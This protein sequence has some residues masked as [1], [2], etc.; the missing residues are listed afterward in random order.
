LLKT[1]AQIVFFTLLSFA[2]HLLLLPFDFMS[3]AV[4]YDSGQ[5]GVSYISKSLDSFYP[6]P[7][8][9]KNINRVAATSVQKSPIVEKKVSR[10]PESAA[11]PVVEAVRTDHSRSITKPELGLQESTVIKIVDPLPEK[12]VEK[13]VPVESDSVVIADMQD[14]LPVKENLEKTTLE[15]QQELKGQPLS[16]ASVTIGSQVGEEFSL[17]EGLTAQDELAT[18]NQ[19]SDYFVSDQGNISNQGFKDALPRYDINPPPQYPQVAKLRGWEGKVVFEASILKNGRVGRLK[20]MA[21]S[22]YRS[23][24]SAARKAISRW[25]F[26]PAT[27]FGLPIDSEVEIPVNF[28][29]KDL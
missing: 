11:T 13:L 8:P 28:S 17:S 26:S 3:S 16:E 25:K 29:L 2:M 19:K 15:P 10:Q 4:P 21:S 7:V 22:G 23:L 14:S 9:Q 20:I 1:T 5:V 18:N 24:D 6:G 12:V 27:S